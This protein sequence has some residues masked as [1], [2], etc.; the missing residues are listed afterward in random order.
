MKKYLRLTL[1]LV[2]CLLFPLLTSADPSLVELRIASVL[3][4]EMGGVAAVT[5]EKNNE[6]MTRVAEVMRNMY[7]YQH[8]KGYTNVTYSD[9]LFG[10]Q[11]FENARIKFAGKTKEQL[12]REGS[13]KP[14]W[15]AALDLAH[16]MVTGTLTS[17]I[18][19]GANAF[20]ANCEDQMK[21]K[22]VAEKRRYTN[23]LQIGSTPSCLIHYNKQYKLLAVQKLP[24]QGARGMKTATFWNWE[25]GKFSHSYQD[26]VEAPADPSYNPKTSQNPSVGAD[27][28]LVRDASSCEFDAI[29]LTYLQ[30]DNVDQYCW[31]CKIVV[32]LVNAYLKVANDAIGSA[33]LPLGKIILKLGFLL[34]LAYF[35]LQQVSSINPVSPAKMAQDILVMGFKVALAYAAIGV[36]IPLIREYYLDPIMG[37]G[38]D[39]GLLIFDSMNQGG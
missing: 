33:T 11:H 38:V 9:V 39:Y 18:A 15:N 23:N 10:G 12:Q 27:G 4:N 36:G 8:S 20:N 30:E 2:L 14:E 28:S 31:Y 35:V 34:W 24:E 19:G 7:N 21:G 13:T 6:P 26:D 32:V 22:S 29:R 5:G 17:N 3:I 25:L 37:T 16:K 1:T